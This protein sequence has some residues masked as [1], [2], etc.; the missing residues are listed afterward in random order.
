M[1]ESGD[2]IGCVS[3]WYQRHVLAAQ[4]EPPRI[5]MRPAPSEM[6]KHSQR[7]SHRMIGEARARFELLHYI[8]AGMVHHARSSILACPDFPSCMELLQRCPRTEVECLLETAARWR[9]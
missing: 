1:K 2:G 4:Q 7:R 9:T 8:C 6:R 5:L 3:K